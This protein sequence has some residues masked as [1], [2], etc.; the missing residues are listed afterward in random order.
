MFTFLFWVIVNCI[1]KN[2]EKEFLSYCIF[3]VS[4]YLN[5]FVQII[6]HL[7]SFSS[8][9]RSSWRAELLAVNHLGF[10][11]A[12]KFFILPSFLKEIFAG[13][14]ILGWQCL[15]FFPNTYRCFSTVFW[16][17]WRYP[18]SFLFLSPIYNACSP[19][20][21]CSPDVSHSPSFNNLIVA[22]HGVVSYRCLVCL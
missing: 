5:Y 10:L 22:C 20:T 11:F 6:F 15:G 16:L 1:L 12:W 17:P 13:Y 2:I 19:A 3:M 9:W 21:G 18:C 8:A 4:D 14:E 7:A